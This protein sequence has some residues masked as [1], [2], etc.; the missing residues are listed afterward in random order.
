MKLSNKI[1]LS[2]ALLSSISVGSF[3]SAIA[4]DVLPA[5]NGL[6]TYHE[7]PRYRESESHPLRIFSYI[8]HPIGWVLREG[9]TRPL[10][11]LAGST[12]ETRSI[13]GFREPFDFRQPSCFSS[14]D[15]APDC[16]ST[17][18]YNYA[19][20]EASNDT[21]S[22]SVANT[23]ATAATF[24]MPEV[25]FETNSSALTDLGKGQVRRLSQI[26]MSNGNA[27]K[28]TA[29]GHTDIR[30]SKDRNAQ[31]GQE[32]A[33]AVKAELITL[34]VPAERLSTVSF[35]S[36]KPLF[37]EDTASAN[38]VNRRVSVAVGN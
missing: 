19:N 7:F 8:L 37:Q 6:A 35:G 34:G 28:V 27:M 33:D 15:T 16:R 29:E 13:M 22:S 38:A 2:I 31:L 17:N 23:T 10:S 14:D 5:D 21:G 18:P 32:R 12:P 30:G 24:S 20:E 3:Q 1:F 4:Q 25:N 26:L 9:I 11:Y 36:D